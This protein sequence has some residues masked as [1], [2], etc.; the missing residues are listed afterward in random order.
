MNNCCQA[1]NSK[2]GSVVNKDLVIWELNCIPISDTAAFSAVKNSTDQPATV[3]QLLS[4][5]EAVLLLSRDKSILSFG[6]AKIITNTSTL[7]K[8]GLTHTFSTGSKTGPTL[9]C[10]ENSFI[11]WLWQTDVTNNSVISLWW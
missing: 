8:R 2:I 3:C 5:T 9:D 10:L 11:L 4:E 7:F 1:N 6:T